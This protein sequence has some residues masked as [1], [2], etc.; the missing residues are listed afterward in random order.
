M[1]LEPENDDYAGGYGDLDLLG[2]MGI[3]AL[4]WLGSLVASSLLLIFTL[5]YE[6]HRVFLAISP[7]A[8][9][10]LYMLV[11][12]CVQYRQ[13]SRELETRPYKP[14]RRP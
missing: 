1:K 6:Y 8:A 7:L 4:I 9:I 12:W 10:S 3:R 2:W 13:L 14:R 11:Y 5:H